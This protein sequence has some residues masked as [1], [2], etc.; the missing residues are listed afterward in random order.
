MNISDHCIAAIITAAARETSSCMHTHNN[1]YTHFENFKGF[2]Q[3]DHKGEGAG[4]NREYI[5]YI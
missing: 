5:I 1:G 2:C 4:I 3:P